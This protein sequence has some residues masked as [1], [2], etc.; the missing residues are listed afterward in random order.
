MFKLILFSAA[1]I[2]SAIV[3]TIIMAV[4]LMF[5]P[6]VIK[7]GYRLSPASYIFAIL[8]A[9]FLFLPNTI[10]TSSSKAKRLLNSIEHID[11]TRAKEY[12]D[13]VLSEYSP[14][15][16]KW[17]DETVNSVQKAKQLKRGQEIASKVMWIDGVFILV[18]FALGVLVVT[19]TLKNASSRTTVRR[20]STREGGSY[21]VPDRMRSSRSSGRYRSHR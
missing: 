15:I 7:K 18:F 2:V 20:T 10:F 16:Q 11:D 21:S 13:I 9:L 5:L 3:I 17:L 1:G 4:L 12:A 8:F 19:V 14:E 6:Q